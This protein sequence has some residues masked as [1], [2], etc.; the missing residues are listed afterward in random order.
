VVTLGPKCQVL[1][2][3]AQNGDYRW[4]IDLVREYHTKVPAWYAGQCPFIDNDR[5]ILAP[6]GDALLIAVDSATGK[7]LWKT[8]NPRDWNMTHSSIIPITFHGTPMYVYCASGGVV[9]VSARDGSILW[10][11]DA[12]KITIA[13]V[14][15]PVLVGE[16]RLFL[17][18]GYNA[19]S[20]MLQLSEQGGKF[21]AKPEFRLPPEVFGSDQQTPI[22]YQGYIYG[23]IPGG[24]L[25]CLDLN[26]HQVWCSGSEYR[27]GLGPYLIAQGMMYILNDTGTLTLVQASPTGYKQLSQAR[28]LTGHDAW[29]P[30]ALAG[31]RLIARDLTRMVCLDV[32]K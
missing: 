27:F 28:V 5:V 18:G 15:T 17:T 26:G 29:G 20:M 7:V 8:P 11:T 21:T 23:V 14:P 9:G 19:G 32:R 25:A 16:G 12:W 24:Q 1:C 6:G 4:G 3:D 30:L 13:N 22:F 2:L 31:G 10:E